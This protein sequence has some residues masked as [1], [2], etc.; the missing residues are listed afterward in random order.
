MRRPVAAVTSLC[1]HAA[2]VAGAALII[3]PLRVEKVRR[4][5]LQLE[6]QE[7]P[8]PPVKQP[9]AR[10]SNAAAPLIDTINPP[11]TEAAPVAEAAPASDSATQP[12]APASPVT[13][14]VA[15]KLPAGPAPALA[16][17]STMP[18]R[19]SAITAD[20]P[21]LLAPRPREVPHTTLLPHALADDPAVPA[22]NPAQTQANPVETPRIAP[23]PSLAQ[24]AQDPATVSQVAAPPGELKQPAR[25]PARLDRSALAAQLRQGAPALPTRGFDRA[26]LGSAVQGARP[27]G[28]GRLTMRQK[29]DL[30]SLIRRQITPCWNPPSLA[31]NPGVVTVSLRIRLEPSGAVNGTPSVSSVDGANPSNQAYVTALIGSVRRAVLRCA[32]LRLPADLYDAWSDVELNFD[33][34]DVL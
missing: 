12:A 6:L 4:D 16:T 8:G 26:A 33:P 7:V 34:R 13:L 22:L 18:P 1:L 11:V 20:N 15:D 23:P 21:P 29:V 25:A 3:F 9:E 28:A 19:A 14:A 27:V 2:M 5:G 31:E 32:P 17:P 24:A 30:V 10:A